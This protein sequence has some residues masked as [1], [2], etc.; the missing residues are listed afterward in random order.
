MVITRELKIEKGFPNPN[1]L[2]KTGTN[3]DEEPERIDLYG[4]DFTIKDDSG[5]TWTPQIATLKNNGVRSDSDLFDGSNLVGA[6][7]GNVIETLV[8]IPSAG[9]T[10]IMRMQTLKKLMRMAEDA[11]NFHTSEWQYKPVYLKWF[12]ESAPGAQYALIYNIDIAVNQ[13]DPTATTSIQEITLTIEREPAWRGIP[14]GANPKLWTLLSR[15]LVPTNSASPAATE[16]NYTHLVFATGAGNY[17]SLLEATI[18]MFDEQATAWIN[19]VD[20][21]AA[22][23]PG[24]APPLVQMYFLDGGSLNGLEQF[25]LSRST[26]RDY[27]PA[28]N[29]EGAATRLRNTLNGWEFTALAP[30]GVVV[31]QP[32]NAA[33]VWRASLANRYILNLAYAAG[34]TT[35]GASVQAASLAKR[36]NQFCARYAVFARINVTGTAPQNVKLKMVVFYNE[37]QI[38]SDDIPLVAGYYAAYMGE[39]DLTVLG[40]RSVS[41][42]GTGVGVNNAL[43]FYLYTSKTNDGNVATVQLWD[44][45]LMP[46]DEP[47]VSILDIGE[48]APYNPPTAI[49]MDNTGYFSSAKD[50]LVAVKMFTNGVDYGNMALSND[51]ALVPG[52]ANRLYFMLRF[53]S[54]TGAMAYDN[55]VKLNIVPR[56]YGVR[57]V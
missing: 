21:P 15:G 12:A 36:V 27:F 30:A 47:S 31:T 38:S 51:L 55:T 6:A 39:L 42:D 7:V 50:S 26:R 53:G 20:I 52:V 41:V 54:G 19:Y 1:S 3:N 17:A 24:D 4:A 43:T 23:L 33:G 13:Y 34:G 5:G 11:R 29:T 14:P 16:F 56:W 35:L 45:V 25:V 2:G 46:I 18:R 40:S 57:D 22:S 32:V 8:V 9:T 37:T 49:Y 28:V 44:I 10:P 48:Q